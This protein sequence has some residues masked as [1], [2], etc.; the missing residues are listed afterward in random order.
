MKVE[1]TDVYKGYKMLVIQKVWSGL[2]KIV[3]FEHEESTEIHL[4]QDE[5][6]FKLKTVIDFAVKFLER[7]QLYEIFA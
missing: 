1:F 5:Y 4:I 2:E 3:A 6:S 7:A